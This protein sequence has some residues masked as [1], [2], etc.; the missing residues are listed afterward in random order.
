MAS[1]YS[2]FAYGKSHFSTYKTKNSQ[3][4]Y[5]FYLPETQGKLIFHRLDN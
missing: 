3:Q 5:L 4:E 2:G 1:S